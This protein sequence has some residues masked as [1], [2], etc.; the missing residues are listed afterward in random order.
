MDVPAR[1]LGEP[2]ADYLRLV[3]RVA[4]DDHVKGDVVFHVVEKLSEFLVETE[5]LAGRDVEGREQRGR[6]VALVVLDPPSACPGRSGG[7]VRSRACI[8]LFPSTLSARSGG[9]SMGPRCS[10]PSR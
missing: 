10:A 2:L 9:R 5:A 1:A 6:A 3:C 7:C 8:W 4:V